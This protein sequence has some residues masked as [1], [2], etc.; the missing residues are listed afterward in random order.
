MT[1]LTAKDFQ[2]EL[3]EL[4]D[5]YAHGKITK[6]EFLDRAAKFA[7]GG[8]TAAAILASMSPGYALAQQVEFT[9]PD[10]LAEYI[11]YPSPQGNGQIRAY[12]VRPV[13]AKG[14]VPAIVVVMRTGVSIPIS[15]TSH[16]AS[17]RPASWRWHPM[18]SAPSAAI[19]EMMRRARNCSSRST[20]E[21]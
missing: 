7:I 12:M 16:V 1:R 2:P 10:I 11:S 20:R 3:L 19:P 6:R 8:L 13:N 5:Y 14:K 21:S 4:Y 15:R 18:A 17:P 9:D